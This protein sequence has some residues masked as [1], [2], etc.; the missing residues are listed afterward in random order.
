MPEFSPLPKDSGRRGRLDVEEPQL[1]EGRRYQLTGRRDQPLSDLRYLRL[2]Y[3][4]RQAAYP[5]LSYRLGSVT[6]PLL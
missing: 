6:P 3:S 1:I 4:R 2:G 5:G